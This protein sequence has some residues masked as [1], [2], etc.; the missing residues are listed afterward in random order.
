MSESE[1]FETREIVIAHKHL[2][3]AIE[4]LAA[5]RNCILLRVHEGDEDTLPAYVFS[6]KNMPVRAPGDWPSHRDL[7]DEEDSDE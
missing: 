4:Q 5:D 7:V 2:W 6:P 1:E 3:D